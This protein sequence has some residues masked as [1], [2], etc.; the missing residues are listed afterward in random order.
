MLA[1]PSS[2]Q[3]TLGEVPL[4]DVLHRRLKRGETVTQLILTGFTEAEVFYVTQICHPE[5]NIRILTICIQNEGTQHIVK[6]IK[7][8]N[9]CYAENTALDLPV[10]DFC[11]D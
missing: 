1:L 10:R 3:S 6:D 8:I 9:H 11:F 4:A 7:L 2:Y 5:Q